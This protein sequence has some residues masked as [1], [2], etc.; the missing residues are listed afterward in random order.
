MVTASGHAIPGQPKTGSRRFKWHGM[1]PRVRSMHEHAQFDPSDEEWAWFAPPLL[2]RSE[3]GRPRTTDPR[4][5]L[6][7]DGRDGMSVY[8]FPP[9]STIQD[10]TWRSEGPFECIGEMFRGFLRRISGGSEELGAIDS[11]SVK[12][13]ED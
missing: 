10:C 12:T 13:A 3:R 5:A 11:Q 7:L 8:C 4:E 1:R 2:P 6:V 9:V